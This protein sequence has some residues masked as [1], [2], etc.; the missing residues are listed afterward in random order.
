M[1]TTLDDEFR[2]TMKDHAAGATG[3]NEPY[4]LTTIRVVAHNI[5]GDEEIWNLTSAEAEKRARRYR[6]IA[7]HALQGAA[8]CDDHADAVRVQPVV[9][10]S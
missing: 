1:A 10:A 6:L 5:D 7:A 4:A 3:A 9:V 8:L 2:R